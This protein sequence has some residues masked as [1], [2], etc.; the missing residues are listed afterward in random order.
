MKK[1]LN[2]LAWKNGSLFANVKRLKEELKEAQTVVEA[3]STNKE[4]KERLS[5]ALHEY[6]EAAIDEEKLL[7]QQAKVQWMQEGIK[8]L[9]S[10][11]M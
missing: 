10:F 9:S 7:A 3:D 5:K 8:T 4:V 1:H 11:T 2:K 6:N